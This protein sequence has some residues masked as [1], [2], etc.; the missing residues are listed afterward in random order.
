MEDI[1]LIIDSSADENNDLKRNLTVVPLT[2]SLGNEDFKD[3]ENLDMK[4]YLAKMDAN[5]EAG[6]T[7]CPSIQDWLNALKGAKKA[8][9]ITMTS[10]LSGTF[11]S[12]L[13]AKEMYLEEHPD[14][15]VITVD[16]KSAG[17]ELA[18]ILEKVEELL[19]KDTRWL[20]L[21]ER[22]AKLMT[23]THLLFVLQS[24]H[25]L[26]LNGRVSPALAKVAKM[27]KINI[28]G[29]ANKEGS[30]EDL[31]KVRGMKRSLKQI[32]KEMAKLNYQNGRVIIDYC[33]NLDQ[34]EQLKEQILAKFPQANISLR[35][36]HGLCSF[37][38]EKGGLM[39]G[40]SEE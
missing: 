27:L 7:A 24:L 25:N 40:F 36:M 17:P 8:I 12:A 22:I 1:K 18:V 16:T 4:N 2:I 26:S 23:K 13:Q 31:G 35:P 30:L 38:A 10:K 33:E 32:V 34:A 5:N 11:S 9:I 21:E 3:D 28:V 14:A 6:K 37:Y 39:V 20:D 19:Q 29:T 15:Q